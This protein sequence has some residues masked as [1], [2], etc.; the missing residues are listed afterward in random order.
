MPRTTY[1][2][3]S[4]RSWWCQP[5]IAPGAVS[6]WPAHRSG[7]SKARSRFIPGVGSA[8]TRSAGPSTRTGRGSSRP[9]MASECH[10][11]P[12]LV[13]RPEE[14][15]ES[16][17]TLEDQVGVVLPGDRDAAVQLDGLARD[18]G[19]CLRAVGLR[20]MGEQLGVVRVRR[21]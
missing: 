12:V 1:R 7:S 20:G 13:R 4:L 21:D 6:T 5:E 11:T 19:E 3:D 14:L 10:E 18:L 16:V 9:L 15:T 17:G 2:L 8:A